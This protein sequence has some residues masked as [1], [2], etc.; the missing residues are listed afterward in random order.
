MTDLEQLLKE[1]RN[2]ELSDFLV[3]LVQFISW[4]AF[5]LLVSWL[6][7]K[8]ITRTVSDNTMRYRARK[9]VRF[10]G[11]FLIL[12][13]ALITITARVQY[14]SVAIG[15]ISAG[16]AFALQEVV[17]SFAGW[18]AIF[19]T[20]M[21][22]P[23]DRIELNKVR[24]D[25][26]DIGL[27][28]TTLMEI[29]EWVGSDNYSGRIVQVSNGAVFKG[30]VHNYS[31]DFPFVWDEINLPV[32]YSSDIR[33]ARQLIN[34]VAQANLIEYANYSKE[35]WKRM[36]RKYLIENA[37]VEPTLTMKLTDNW[38]EF[39][40]RYVVDY[41]RR[42]TTR[43][44]LFTDILEAVDK[45]NGKVALASATIAITGLPDVRVD[46]RQQP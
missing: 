17:L 29:G 27:T 14:F 22:K 15:L 38:V 7:Q 36:V 40:L 25:V 5:I 35:H 8:G 31:S 28:K 24:G 13:L 19:T 21:Y 33:Q 46:L 39:N 37:N 32:T 6:I 3:Q 34:D 30:P 42:R 16:I 11:Y 1:F 44:K 26:I 18:I 2:W 10:G 43:D 20:N 41:K 4:M 12:M 9:A 45:T 23:G